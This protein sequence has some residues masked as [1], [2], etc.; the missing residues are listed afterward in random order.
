MRSD[1]FSPSICQRGIEFKRKEKKRI[2][3]LKETC[4]KLLLA[5]N[6]SSIVNFV[7][8][9]KRNPLMLIV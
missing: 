4:K 6:S 8:K 5:R 7:K 2:N 1:P 3:F 9:K